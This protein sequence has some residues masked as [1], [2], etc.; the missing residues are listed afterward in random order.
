MSDN[1][2]KNNANKVKLDTEDIANV[3]E[4]ITANNHNALL[5]FN[6]AMAKREDLSV[7]IGK[8][9]TQILRFGIISILMISGLMFFLI[10]SLSK[11]IDTM[12]SNITHIST[13]MGNMDKSFTLVT[14]HLARMDTTMTGLNQHISVMSQDIHSVPKISS[15]VHKLNQS[16]E[17]MGLSM[18]SMTGDMHVLNQ[19]TTGINQQFSTLIQ[20]VGTMTRDVNQMSRPMKFFP[21]PN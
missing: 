21:F 18:R 9:T 8:R 15:T 14:Q 13:T 20:H 1:T 4:S 16:I 19:S 12:A 10:Q 6:E 11:H 7:R 17:T 5:M 3:L 2:S